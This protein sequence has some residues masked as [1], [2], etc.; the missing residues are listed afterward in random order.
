MSVRACARQCPTLKRHIL[1]TVLDRRVVT[2]DGP[3]IGRGPP[4]VE[5][6]R[7]RRRHVTQR[8]QGRDPIIFETTIKLFN[9]YHW[10]TQLTDLIIRTLL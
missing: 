1:I 9:F 7:D 10:P 2:L 5:C 3:P 8:S 4:R 6:L